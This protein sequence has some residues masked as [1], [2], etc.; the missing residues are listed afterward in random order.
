MLIS[1]Q[2]KPFYKNRDKQIREKTDQL[3]RELTGIP[4]ADIQPIETISVKCLFQFGTNTLQNTAAKREKYVQFYRLNSILSAD[5]YTITEFLKTATEGNPENYPQNDF[6]AA[7]AVLDHEDFLLEYGKHTPHIQAA[8][9]M[10]L[11]SPQVLVPQAC[12]L[13]RN[14]PRLQFFG[15]DSHMAPQPARRA[16]HLNPLLQPS[17]IS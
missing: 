1:E 16:G 13:N 7:D 3:D 17:A 12:P 15:P 2:R 10:L 4:N 14:E 5:P 8:F 6:I 11:D 9:Q